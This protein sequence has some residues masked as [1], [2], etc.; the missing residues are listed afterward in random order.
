MHSVEITTHHLF[1]REAN[2]KCWNI[3]R[4]FQK[5]CFSELCTSLEQHGDLFDQL[6]GFVCFT[7]GADVKKVSTM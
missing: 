2:E 5:T 4:K 3:I 7:Y 1:S 6:E